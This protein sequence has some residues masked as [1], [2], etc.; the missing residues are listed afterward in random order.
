MNDGVGN[1]V[2]NQNLNPNT[3]MTNHTEYVKNDAYSQQNMFLNTANRLSAEGLLLNFMQNQN[4]AIMAALAN[5][6]TAVNSF[7]ASARMIPPGQANFL[8]NLKV[9]LVFP[10]KVDAK[11]MQ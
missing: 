5:R 3:M 6:H 9:D 11:S 1:G 7:N 10:N 4:N 2:N 8:E